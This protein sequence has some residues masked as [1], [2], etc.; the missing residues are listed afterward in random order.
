LA[1]LLGRE[2]PR[3]P[4]RHRSLVTLKPDHAEGLFLRNS[5]K[6][7]GGRKAYREA[8]QG[9]DRALALSPK[10]KRYLLERARV[11]GSIL[12][13]PAALADLAT[14]LKI[15]PEHGQAYYFRGHILFLMGRK[16]DAND[17]FERAARLDP[18]TKGDDQGFPSEVRK[19]MA[20]RIQRRRA[21]Q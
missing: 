6:H 11:K 3:G 1:L 17:D 12:D 15:D 5:L 19:L 18:T 9:Y 2:L 21:S 20:C 8:L 7:Y 13:D 16:K 14:L 4:A 10:E